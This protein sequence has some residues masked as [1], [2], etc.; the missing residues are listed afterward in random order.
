MAPRP[1]LE[2]GGR[3]QNTPPRFYYFSTPAAGARGP[4]LRALAAATLASGLR[5]RRMRDR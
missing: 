1:M 4:D 3:K 5:V 2:R